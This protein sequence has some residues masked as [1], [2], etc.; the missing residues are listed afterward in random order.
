MI[1]HLVLEGSID[2]SRAEALIRKQ[3]VI[4][5]AMDINPEAQCEQRDPV[6]PLPGV[7]L[8]RDYVMG[9][10][11][12]YTPEIITDLI[13]QA[14]GIR[15]SQLDT[16][17]LQRIGNMTDRSRMGPLLKELVHRNQPSPNS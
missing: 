17:I 11:K 9:M 2:I 13:G 7:T 8:N 1:T 5:L 3:T 4:D 14:K 12:L 6:M 10:I 16:A 15:M